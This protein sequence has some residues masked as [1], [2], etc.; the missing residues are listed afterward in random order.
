MKKTPLNQKFPCM[1]YGQDM[2]K[3]YPEENESIEMI[4]DYMLPGR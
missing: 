3:S 1:R 2:E 4:A